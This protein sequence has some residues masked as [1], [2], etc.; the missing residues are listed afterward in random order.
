LLRSSAAS[1]LMLAPEG[2]SES[3]SGIEHD[4]SPMRR[5]LE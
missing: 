4:D 5:A 3:A 1:A 2:A